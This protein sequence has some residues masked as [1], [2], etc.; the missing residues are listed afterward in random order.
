MDIPWTCEHC[1]KKYKTFK[2]YTNHKCKVLKKLMENREKETQEEKKQISQQKT[3]QKPQQTQQKPK[4]RKKKISPHIR[5]QVWEKYVG[6]NIE[7]KCFCCFKNKITPF[8]HYNTFH[9]GHI[10]SEANGGE[11]SLG[12]LLPICGDCNKD[13]GPTNWDDYLT[14]STNFRPRLYGEKIPNLTHLQAQKIQKWYKHLYKS[15]QTNKK[16]KQ[17]KNF[18]KSSQNKKLRKQNKNFSK[19]SQNKKLRKQNKKKKKQ[20]NYARPTKSF[21]NKTKQ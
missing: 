9:A 14:N 11:I 16:K 1:N 7:A 4:K 20:P 8:T 12:N 10:K 17:N 5:F 6:N 13:M 21:L 19:S 3:K 15:K 18:S 2:G